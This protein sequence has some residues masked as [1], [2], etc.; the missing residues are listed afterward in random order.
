[1]AT[2]NPLTDAE[3]E[4]AMKR[5]VHLASITRGAAGKPVALLYTPS[6]KK[7]SITVDGEVSGQGSNAVWARLRYN[8]L[9]GLGE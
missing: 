1:M 7:F 4:S 5:P 9:A 6:S 2:F 8:F 3:V